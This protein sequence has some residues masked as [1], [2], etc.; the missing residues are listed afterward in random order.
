MPVKRA[1]EEML[2][3]GQQHLVGEFPD[4]RFLISLTVQTKK[5]M[6]VVRHSSDEVGLA[7]GFQKHRA[8]VNNASEAVSLLARETESWVGKSPGVSVRVSFQGV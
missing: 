8:R 5:L 4:V 1:T 6:H 3:D 7:G 2:P